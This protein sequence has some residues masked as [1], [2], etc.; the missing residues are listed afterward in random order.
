MVVRKFVEEIVTNYQWS[1]QKRHCFPTNNFQAPYSCSEITEQLTFARKITEH[2]YSCSANYRAHLLVLGKPND[3]I[4]LCSAH[5][6]AISIVLEYYRV[7]IL[8]L[9][10]LASTFTRAR[11]FVT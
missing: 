1:L 11:K 3:Y 2:I 7:H 4:N 8:V 6:R 10:N 5:Q 9:G